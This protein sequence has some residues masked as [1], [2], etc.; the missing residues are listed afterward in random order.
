MPAS[1]SGGRQAAKDRKNLPNQ[2]A[3]RQ[4]EWCL[5][6]P[7]EIARSQKYSGCQSKTVQS[8]RVGPLLQ[9]IRPSSTL[10]HETPWHSHP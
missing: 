5:I 8:D 10:G 3:H 1:D 9:E 2:S 7:V 6:S 4:T